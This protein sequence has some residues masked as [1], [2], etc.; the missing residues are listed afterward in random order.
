MSTLTALDTYQHYSMHIQWS[1]VDNAYLVTV[2]KLPGC[3]THGATYEDAVR[4]GQD[5]VAS[6]I[7]ANHAWGRPIPA[8]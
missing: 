8:P 1:E 5:A 4:R 2:P 3:V 7:E 6:W